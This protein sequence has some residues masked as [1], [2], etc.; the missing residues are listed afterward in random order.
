M[1]R[2]AVEYLAPHHPL[3][4]AYNNR[5]REDQ[6]HRY[7]EEDEV[8]PIRQIIKHHYEQ[9]QG[10]RCCYCGIHLPTSHGRVWDAE[11]IVPKASHPQFLFE[12]K[13]LAVSCI[14]CNSSKLDTRILVNNAVVNYPRTSDA[15]I[16][17][18]PHF[19]NI[20]DHIAVSLGKFYIPKTVKG[21]K[22]ILICRLTRYSY[23]NLGWDSG[24]CDSEVLV[25]KYDEFISAGDAISQRRIIQE[26]LMI[27]QVQVTRSLLSSPSNVLPPQLSRT[28]ESEI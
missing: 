23:E 13:N 27:A 24:L 19:D 7:W 16:I 5:Q 10:F 26:L 15:F 22:T 17:V 14:D 20:D 3:V 9:E 4:N 28:D 25:D 6:N 1:I 12:P 8:N 21:E 11:H 2:S 18:H